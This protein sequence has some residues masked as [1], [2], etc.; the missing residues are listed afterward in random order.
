MAC[1]YIHGLSDVQS[2]DIGENTYIWQYVVILPGAKIGSNCNINALV[3]IEND[4][5][6]G[7]NV[8]V[9]SGVQIWDGLRIADNVFIGPNVTFS[10]DLFPRSKIRPSEF[11]KT[12]IED[13]ASVGANATIIAGVTIGAY[14]LIGAGSVVT[15]DVPPHGLVYG[16]PARIQGYVCK[17][18][19]RIE[20]GDTCPSC[21]FFL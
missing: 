15:K 13:H 9:K 19:Q 6:I 2:K 17:C 10:N 4:V 11:V 5:I 21:G 7:N 18:G 12:N 20:K 14:S 1:Q 3:F 16:N 8:T